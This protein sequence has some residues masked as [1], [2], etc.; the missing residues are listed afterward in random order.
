MTN[1]LRIITYSECQKKPTK[2]AVL[3]LRWFVGSMQ[4]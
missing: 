4:F 3:S 1:K 2:M